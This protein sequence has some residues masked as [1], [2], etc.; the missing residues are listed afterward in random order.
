MVQDNRPLPPDPKVSGTWFEREV[1]IDVRR[2]EDAFSMLLTFFASNYSKGAVEE[3]LL[4]RL[5]AC[6]TDDEGEDSKK[7]MRFI[8][9]MTEK[10][11]KG[12]AFDKAQE[13]ELKEREK[14]C[15]WD[16]KNFFCRDIDISCRCRDIDL[17]WKKWKLVKGYRPR[18]VERGFHGDTIKK[19]DRLEQAIWRLKAV[20]KIPHDSHYGLYYIVKDVKGKGKKGNADQVGLSLIGDQSDQAKK[21]I[22]GLTNRGDHAVG[23]NWLVSTARLCMCSTQRRG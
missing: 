15:L 1:Y 4:M 19:G 13:D 12:V 3:A 5:N 16:L 17:E 21:L 23:E 6:L 20:T 9:P 2:P 7:P 11:N 18:D 14:P 10:G 8:R 22:V